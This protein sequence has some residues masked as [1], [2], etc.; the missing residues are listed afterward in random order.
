MQ[1]DAVGEEGEEKDN[2]GLSRWHPRPP[3][4]SSMFFYLIRNLRLL[5][6]RRGIKIRHYEG[7][8]LPTPPPPCGGATNYLHG[9][10]DIH[11]R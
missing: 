1:V 10:Q 9:C 5:F 2:I 6:G 4:T 8:M 3:E 7:D 11:Y